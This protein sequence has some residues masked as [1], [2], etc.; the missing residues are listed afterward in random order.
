MN[1]REELWSDRKALNL[2]QATIKRDLLNK[3]ADS[4]LVNKCSVDWNSYWRNLKHSYLF[5]DFRY[6]NS[7][8]L[9][10]GK[11]ML[12]GTCIYSL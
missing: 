8:M 3:K 10:W 11:L 1:S 7:Q 2:G 9:L 4:Y 6:F 12:E 5:L